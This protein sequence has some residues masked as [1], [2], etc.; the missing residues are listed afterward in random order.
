MRTGK[1]WTQAIPFHHLISSVISFLSFGKSKQTDIPSKPTILW[2]AGCFL[3]CVSS[4]LRSASPK[5][6][7]ALPR[8]DGGQPEPGHPAAG[9]VQLRE[10]TRR[11]VDRFFCWGQGSRG[12]MV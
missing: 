6:D 2:V 1:A 5:P 8:P 9:D 7:S 3:G 10:L 4:P 12:P 11:G